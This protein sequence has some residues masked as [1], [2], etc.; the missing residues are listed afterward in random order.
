M[1]I[2]NVLCSLWVYTW[3]GTVLG[4]LKTLNHNWGTIWK[5]ANS[6]QEWKTF[7]AALHASRHKSSKYV[8]KYHLLWRIHA[9]KGNLPC[10]KWFL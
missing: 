6:K 4:E 7:F 9:F 8:T 2:E 3:K 10:E 5:L 1:V